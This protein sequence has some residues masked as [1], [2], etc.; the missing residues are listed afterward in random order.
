MR[1]GHTA[2]IP[3]GSLRHSPAQPAWPTP[4]GQVSALFWPLALI[5]VTGA[6]LVRHQGWAIEGGPAL[7]VAIAVMLIGGLPHGACDIALAAVAW[8]TGGRALGLI[9][10]AYLGVAGVMLVLW[11]LAPVAA[12]LMF[13]ALAGV[14]FGEDWT[15]LP[16]GLLRVMAGLAVIT[17]A[18]LG[19]P[20]AVGAL[21]AA[22]T[23]SAWAVPIA[24]WA[25]AAAPVTLLVTLVG[26]MLAWQAGHRIWV[27]AQALSYACLMALPPLMGFA[28]FFVGLHAPLHWDH[29]TQALPGH[30]RRAAV[31][32][33][34]GLTL[35]VL[36]GW[37]AAL[38]GRGLIVPGAI[39]PLLVGG[40]AFRLLSVV[41]A[42]HLA[43]SLALERRLAP[44][45]IDRRNGAPTP[46]GHGQ[47]RAVA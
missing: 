5:A 30:W 24:R 27:L 34:A 39:S 10:A 44:G 6:A 26:L 33:G 32:Q 22:M 47:A 19:Q 45:R 21:F 8:Q 1:L 3:D 31:W 35:L 9:V 28:V 14:H 37:L 13:L 20:G 15:M 4:V 23:H 36:A 7:W 18:A 42:P 46:A 16:R 38:W 17:T 41:A 2:T 40:D 29:V 43:L 11:W 25:A 12:L